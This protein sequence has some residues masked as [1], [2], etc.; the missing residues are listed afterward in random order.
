[1]QERASM[2][3]TRSS[4]TLKIVSFEFGNRVRYGPGNSEVVIL[5]YRN[6]CRYCTRRCGRDERASF[7]TGSIGR[8]AR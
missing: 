6:F 8:I 5:I 3:S 1:M 2:S 7:Y 4:K